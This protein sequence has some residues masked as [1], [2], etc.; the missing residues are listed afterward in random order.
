[1]AIAKFTNY[2]DASD[3]LM[4]PVF[5]SP[6]LVS[7]VQIERPDFSTTT[8]II[9]S[10]HPGRSSFHPLCS[11]TEGWRNK[12]NFKESRNPSLFQNSVP[13]ALPFFIHNQ[14]IA[15]RFLFPRSTTLSWRSSIVMHAE[16]VSNC[17]KS[18]FVPTS[19][20]FS[21]QMSRSKLGYLIS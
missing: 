1:M 6:H 3:D 5:H 12:Q 20:L 7:Y 9:T 15:V 8:F 13:N 18:F 4:M 14:I 17:P 10:H 11:F 2:V 19:K 16:K 21:M